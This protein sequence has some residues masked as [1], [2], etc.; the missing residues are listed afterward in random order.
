MQVAIP[1]WQDRV[2]PVFDTART[3]L[4]LGIEGGREVERSIMHLM[5]GFPPLRVRRLRDRGVELLICGAISRPFAHLCEG[6]GIRVIPWVAGQV[7]EVLAAFLDDRLPDPSFTMPGCCRAR[8]RRR[9]M[10]G[11]GGGRGMGPGRGKGRG[12]NES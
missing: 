5:Q 8:R 12:R 1:V 6:A 11:P 7:D 10:H 3:V 2:S 4:L 9:G